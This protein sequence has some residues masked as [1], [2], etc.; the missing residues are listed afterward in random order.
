MYWRAACFVLLAVDLVSPRLVFGQAPEA[1]EVSSD[2][3]PGTPAPTSPPPSSLP[4]PSTG[5]YTSPSTQDY[6]FTPPQPYGTAPPGSDAPPGAA[7]RLRDPRYGD[8]HVDRVVLVPTGETHPEGTL[9]FSSYEIVLLQAGYAVS[10]RTQITLTSMPPLARETVVPFDLTLKTVLA[11]APVFRVAALASLSGIAGIEPGTVV[12]GRAGGVV[13]L[14][15][16]RTC[17]SSASVGSTLVLA[18]PALF[19]L[20]GAGLIVS[21]TEHVSV[22][23][24]VDAAIPIGSALNRYSGLAIAPG[25][26][27]S[28]EH[29]GLDFAFAHALDVLEGPGIPFLAATYR[30]GGK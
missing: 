11:R 27:F 4:P 10:D 29:L 13:Q 20:N 15:F 21:A 17:R 30:T 1:P 24:E 18:G 19:A 6:G 8:A 23:L 3:S 5:S 12:L 2:K 25:V 26:R 16:E 7:F 14:C 28:G 9:Y 22:L